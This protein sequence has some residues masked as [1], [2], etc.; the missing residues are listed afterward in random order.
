MVIT[1]EFL[2]VEIAGM[3]AEMQKA[4]N[5]QV[6]T[7]AVIASFEMLLAKLATPEPVPEPEKQDVKL[8]PD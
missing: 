1:Q 8:T 2:Q 3:K 5:F 6:Q 4:V 7:T